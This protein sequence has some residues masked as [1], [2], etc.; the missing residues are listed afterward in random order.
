MLPGING[1][2]VARL[3]REDARTRNA[4][5]VAVTALVSETFRATAME[6]GCDMFIRKPVVVSDVVTELVQLLGRRRAAFEALPEK[7]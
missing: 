6:A 5:I 7:P 3:L 4:A 1:F 2:A